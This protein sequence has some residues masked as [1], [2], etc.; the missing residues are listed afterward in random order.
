MRLDVT[1]RFQT[2]KRGVDGTYGYFTPGTP[3][4]FLSH[5]DP[6]SLIRETQKRQHDNMFEF[7][8]VIAVRH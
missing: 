5:R 8:E 6:I 2:I 7:T 1:L 4:D 3:F